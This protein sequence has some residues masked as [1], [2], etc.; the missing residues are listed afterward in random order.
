VPYVGAKDALK[1]SSADDERVGVRNSD[2]AL[3]LRMRSGR[4]RRAS[5]SK[6]AR[7]ASV[8]HS[9]R[10]PWLPNCPSAEPLRA[11]LEVPW[12]QISA[13][14][15]GGGVLNRASGK[16]IRADLTGGQTGRSRRSQG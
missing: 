2:H 5:D 15:V 7:E 16:A 11:G 6:E 10:L 1:V 13:N 9:I 14:S 8:R 4:R 3:D 12:T